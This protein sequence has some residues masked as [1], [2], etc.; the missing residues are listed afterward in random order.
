MPLLWYSSFHC[1]IVLII[2]ISFFLFLQSISDVQ[3]PLCILHPNVFRYKFTLLSK[4]LRTIIHSG[5]TM[6]LWGFLHA[7][8]CSFTLGLRDWGLLTSVSILLDI[9]QNQPHNFLEDTTDWNQSTWLIWVSME[10][11]QES[12]AGGS[13]Y[14]STNILK[15]CNYCKVKSK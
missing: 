7:F 6:M 8:A 4:T 10:S 13:D 1:F 3:L 12:S 2:K 5:E 14:R 11:Q 9:Q 15:T